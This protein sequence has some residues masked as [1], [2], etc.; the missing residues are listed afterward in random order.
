M[1]QIASDVLQIRSASEE[2]G[3]NELPHLVVIDSFV[4]TQGPAIITQVLQHLPG[5]RPVVLVNT[6]D[7]A[8]MRTC[9]QAGACGYIVKKIASTSLIASLHLIAMGEK[10]MPSDLAGELPEAPAT[11]D[12]GSGINH[13][14]ES[15]GLS[16]RESEILACLVSGKPNKIISRQ[17][18]ISEATVK[19]HV[20]AILRKTGVQNRTQAAIWAMAGKSSQSTNGSGEH[21]GSQGDEASSA[22]VN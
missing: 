11:G 20:K 19:V 22:A 9:F 16:L 17:L 14:I 8:T 12:G 1:V 13:P 3:G 7:F 15:A 2:S 21:R 18:S 5:L 4:E 6:F 10:V